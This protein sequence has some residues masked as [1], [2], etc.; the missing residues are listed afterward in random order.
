MGE[1]DSS[2]CDNCHLLG[3]LLTQKSLVDAR[4][5]LTAMG[6]GNLPHTSPLILPPVVMARKSS[7]SSVNH[8]TM[9]LVR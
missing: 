6:L 2:A 9:R 3:S 7:L 8:Y 1:N 5:Y 4:I